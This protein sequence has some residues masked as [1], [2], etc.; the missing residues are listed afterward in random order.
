MT[1]NFNVFLDIDETMISAYP[2]EELDLKNPKIKAKSIKFRFHNMDDYYI[3]FE[4]PNLQNFL[5]YLFANFNVSIWSAASK[6]YVLYVISNIILTKPNR[7]LDFILYSYHCSVS[8]KIKKTSKSLRLLFD[9]FKLPGYSVTNTIIIDDLTTV[10]N[11]QKCNCINIKPFKMLDDESDKDKE[12]KILI[13]KLK[14]FQKVYTQV[15]GRACL[16]KLLNNL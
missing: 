15:K 4:R 13:D 16:T 9:T 1:K 12:L 8:K 2:T 11:V 3:V 14:K 10:C 7:R 6:D 5:D